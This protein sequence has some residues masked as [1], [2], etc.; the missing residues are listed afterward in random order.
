MRSRFHIIDSLLIGLI[1]FSYLTN[2]V[3]QEQQ[4]KHS[5]PLVEISL[6]IKND[7][8]GYVY[9]SSYS[10]K[11]PDISQLS[12]ALNEALGTSIGLKARKSNV[13]AWSYEGISRKLLRQK[14]QMIFGILIIIIGQ[15]RK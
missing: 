1:L 8:T 4:Y 13:Y 14:D 9:I 3:S 7:G 6:Y 10:Q 5:G 15:P 12:G 11:K 2:A